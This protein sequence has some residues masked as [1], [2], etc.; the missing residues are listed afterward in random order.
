M[1]K[2]YF[3][4]IDPYAAQWLRNLIAG[5]HIAPGDVDERSIV[6]VRPSDLEGY[7]Q[8]HF[9]AG[10]GGWP[11]AFRMAGWPDDR[12]VWSGSCP[13]QGESVAGKRLGKDDPRHLWP[14]WFPLIK[15]KRPSVI[16]GEQV[17]RAAGTHWLDGVCTDL[18]SIGY[19]YGAAVI[20]ASAVGARHRRD[21]LWFVANAAGLHDR[22]GSS[23]PLERQE[24][25]FGA[26]GV[27]DAVANANGFAGHE[28]GAG[29]GS[30]EQGGRNLDRSCL[31]SHVCDPD[32]QGLAVGEGQRSDAREKQPAIVGTNWWAVEPGMGRVAHGVPARVGKLR[33]Y[34]NAIVPQLAAEVIGA[35]LDVERSAA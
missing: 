28:R 23:Q 7:A 35:F 31:G 11:L 2:A 13:C 34:G 20:P 26:C 27:G 14:A 18:E 10:L 12:A 22:C 30:Q 19:T 33:A 3:N 32:R 5:G 29:H 15:G 9:F 4:E 21:R 17:A 25:Q 1:A 24:P 16:F 6:D 8:C